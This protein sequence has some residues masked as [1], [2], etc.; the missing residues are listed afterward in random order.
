MLPGSTPHPS[1]RFASARYQMARWVTSDDPVELR[2][3][4][5]ANALNVRNLDV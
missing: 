2:R 3:F 5:E 1:A 4:I